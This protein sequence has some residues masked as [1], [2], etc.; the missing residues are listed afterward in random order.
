M[1]AANNFRSS[2]SFGM[3]TSDFLSRLEC[4][5]PMPLLWWFGGF[6]FFAKF[7]LFLQ[8]TKPHS[9]SPRFASP[10]TS[11]TL[12]L[13]QRTKKRRSSFSPLLSS[14]RLCCL[15]PEEGAESPEPPELPELQKGIARIARAIRSI[16]RE[17]F[18]WY[19]IILLFK[20]IVRVC[21]F[22]VLT[23]VITQ[24]P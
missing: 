1:N 23:Q 15:G 21:V 5:L 2:T 9:H 22:C 10:E 4:H 7:S 8:P 6:Y 13:P 14:L 18:P 12:R 17:V 16:P 3:A 11:T 19:F 24:S 20:I